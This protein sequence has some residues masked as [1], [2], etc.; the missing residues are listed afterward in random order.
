MKKFSKFILCVM[1]SLLFVGAV[2]AAS[3]S[4]KATTG[5]KVATVGST[6]DVKVT[7]SST[8]KLGSWKFGI[9]YDNSK[10][11]LVSGD[12]LV[13]GS[14]DGK[15][16][17][18][19]SYTYRFR[20]I[21]SGSASIN[22]VNA[23]IADFDTVQYISTS[24]SGVTV[25]LKTQAEIQASYSKNNDLKSLSV[26]GYE[27][28]PAFDK[29]TL[30]Y[31]V[32]V[33]DTITQ[34]Q[35]NASLADSKA[36]VSGAGTIDISEGNNTVKIV[37]TAENGSTKTYTL[38][39]D[40]KDLNPIEVS[41]GD[42]TFTVVKKS[43]QLIETTGFVLGSI[44]IE[45]IEVPAYKN[46]L[47]DLVLIGLKNDM[48]KIE[49]YIYD[50]ESNS[51]TK[52][53]EV[54]GSSLILYPMEIASAPE[55]FSKSKI[56]IN[57]V[58]YEAMKSDYSDEFF[59]I[60][61]M[62]IENGEKGYFVFDEKTNGLIS[63]NNEVFEKLISENKEFK[64][65]LLA[66]GGGVVLLFM[67]CLALNSKISKLKKL[68]RKISASDVNASKDEQ[69]EIESSKTNNEEEPSSEMETDGE[70]ETSFSKSEQKRRKK[71]HDR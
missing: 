54:R 24:T 10:L 19:I 35:V 26:E 64:L 15:I 12:T 62:N 51:Y 60:Y 63:Y 38:N 55:G 27:I 48:G 14:N 61:A 21:K 5:T 8:D 18:S 16:N 23:E 4:V 58:D 53:N 30:E 2:N 45:G 41:V 46:E 9:S 40:V 20:A 28:T 47:A 49:M 11:S 29:D 34:I 68:L 59:L 70:E 25:T 22:I 44:S 33:P 56:T 6:F 57:G 1:M 52:Y 50:E 66:A 67:L 71:Q 3:G 31:K 43:D 39:V 17:K 13:V 37:V 65:Y 32:S 69:R 36:H 42:G 7:V